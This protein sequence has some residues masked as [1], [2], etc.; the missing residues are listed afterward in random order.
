MQP[1]LDSDEECIVTKA[2]ILKALYMAASG[3]ISESD[4]TDWT[5]LIEGRGNRGAKGYCL[6]CRRGLRAQRG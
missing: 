5:E 2:D 6:K 4:L 1:A 3:Q